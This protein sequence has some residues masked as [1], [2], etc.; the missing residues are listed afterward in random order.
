VDTFSIVKFHGPQS[1]LATTFE[2]RFPAD[3]K[4]DQ[5]WIGENAVGDWFYAPHF[6]YSARGLVLYLLEVVSR[7]GELCGQHRHSARRL[8]R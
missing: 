1:G 4:T 5:M 2:G 8:A 3:I 7:D 6:T